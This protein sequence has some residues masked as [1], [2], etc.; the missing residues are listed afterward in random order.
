LRRFQDYCGG[1]FFSPS[2]VREAERDCFSYR[3]VTE[4]DFVDFSW[5]DF[6]SAAVD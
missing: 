5:R 6:F 3:G 4:Q 1:D 2:G